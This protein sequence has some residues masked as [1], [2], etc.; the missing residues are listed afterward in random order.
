MNFPSSSDSTSESY[1]DPTLSTSIYGNLFSISV[2]LQ[3]HVSFT[4]LRC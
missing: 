3:Q 2:V 1:G 4:S